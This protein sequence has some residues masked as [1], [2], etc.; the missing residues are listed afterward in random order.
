VGSYII[1]VE[2][3]VLKNVI[4]KAD[5]VCGTLE[6]SMRKLALFSS[7]EKFYLIATDGCLTGYFPISQFY[8]KSLPPFEIP[9]DVVKQFVSELSGKVSLL[10]QD[11]T[12]SFKSQSEL[13]RLRIYPVQK[14]KKFIIPRFSEYTVFSK[15]KFVSELDFVSSFLEE[16]SYTDWHYNGHRLEMISQHLGLVAYSVIERTKYDA[17]NENITNI[18]NFSISIPYVSSRHLIKVLEGDETENIVVS[19]DSFKMEIVIKS[20]N[21]YTMCSDISEHNPVNIRDICAKFPTNVKLST[22]LFQRLLRRALISGRFSDVEIYSRHGEIVVLS[23]HGSIVYKGSIPSST[24]QEFSVKTKAY[25]L[26]SALNRIGS[27]YVSIGIVN[28]Y[29]LM[30][31][32]SATRFL[33]LKNQRIQ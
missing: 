22:A 24:E 30:A 7:E 11:G 19:F 9:L 15:R 33:I 16:G 20:E 5:K 31:P 14:E 29:V 8:L 18:A 3:D 13:L 28:D 27:Q 6:P 1:E 23:Q 17:D 10:F 4:K 12:L 32:P 26:R 2:A 25:M 21:I